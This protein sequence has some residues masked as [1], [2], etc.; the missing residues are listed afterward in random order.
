MNK[1]RQ[2]LHSTIDQKNAFIEDLKRQ[3]EDLKQ[4]ITALEQDLEFARSS[5]D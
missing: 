3:I 4:R 2:D 5:G 1:E